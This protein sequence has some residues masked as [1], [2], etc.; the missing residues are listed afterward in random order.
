MPEHLG[1]SRI[2]Q[3]MKARYPV[4]LCTYSHELLMHFLQGSRLFLIL[5]IINDHLKI[6]V[7]FLFF[8]DDRLWWLG[9][10]CCNSEGLAPL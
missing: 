5:G 2:A 7:R 10:T 6:E 4:S 1:S 9:M 8:F 3:A